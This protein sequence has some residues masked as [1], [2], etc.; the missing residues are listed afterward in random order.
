MKKIYVYYKSPTKLEFR[1]IE[2]EFDS[3]I[4]VDLTESEVEFLEALCLSE[5]ETEDYQEL[6]DFLHVL[7]HS[8]A[9]S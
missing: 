6:Q 4:S 1:G 9:A 8:K 5:E 3:F 2:P 7:Y